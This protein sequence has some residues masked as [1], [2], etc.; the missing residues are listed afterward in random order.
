MQNPT[1]EQVKAARTAAGHSQ[2]QAADTI[3]KGLRT[4]QQWEKGERA[5]DPALFELYCL[6]TGQSKPSIILKKI[7]YPDYRVETG[8]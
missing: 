7:G 1:P 2:T 4:W 3:Y 6:K 5:M 8:L